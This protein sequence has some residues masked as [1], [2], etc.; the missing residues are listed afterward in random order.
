MRPILPLHV[1]H[2]DQFQERL[3]HEC[4]RLQRVVP[5]FAAQ[6][7]LRQ[8]V[9]LVVND[10]HQLIQCIPISLSPCLQELC[11]FNWRRG[12][13]DR[14]RTGEMARPPLLQL[15]EPA[16][17]RVI[18]IRQKRTTRDV[19]DVERHHLPENSRISFTV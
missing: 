18:Q 9:Q 13:A 19:G 8:P 16:R 15:R 3:V 1:L 12:H 5:A 17:I 14:S 2:V 11:D 10:R 6:V 4:R 7:L